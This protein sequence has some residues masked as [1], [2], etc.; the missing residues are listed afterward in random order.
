MKKFF[1]LYLKPS[2]IIK[3]NSINYLYKETTDMMNDQPNYSGINKNI[4]NNETYKSNQNLYQ[5]TKSDLNFNNKNNNLSLKNDEESFLEVLSKLSLRLDDQR[6]S[7]RSNEKRNKYLFSNKS[8]SKNEKY[9]DE[10]FNLIM[11]NQISRRD[12]Q[13]VSKSKFNLLILVFF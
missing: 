6:C 9:N 10:F 1:L 2:S 3:S 4:Y 11:K 12:V 13:K 8:N 5:T 7:F